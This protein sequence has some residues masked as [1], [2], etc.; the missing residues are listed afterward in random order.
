MNYIKLLTRLKFLL[1]SR[2]YSLRKWIFKRSLDC[3]KIASRY[4]KN[5][6]V[7]EKPIQWRSSFLRHLETAIITKTKNEI[8]LAPWQT[9][10]LLT[11]RVNL[12][13]VS[14]APNGLSHNLAAVFRILP[15]SA[16]FAAEFYGSAFARMVFLL[17]CGS[18]HEICANCWNG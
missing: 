5:Q 6:N 10:K 12:N 16:S 1:S 14:F 11:S 2:G 18:W 9:R 4:K 13:R 8:R 15:Y 17:F 3:F 7:T